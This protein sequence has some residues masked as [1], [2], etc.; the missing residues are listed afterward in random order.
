MG[1]D[2]YISCSL[3]ICKETGKLY[4]YGGARFE[5]I[6]NIPQL[7][8]P[9]EHREFVRM[10]GHLFGIYTRLVTDETSTSV[11]NFLD[12]Y[13][14]WS[15]ITESSDFEEYAEGWNE[16]MHERFYA[17]LIWFSLQDMNYMICWD[18]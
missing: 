12:K 8:V 9:E 2:I 1:F 6:Y 4:Y 15:D 5:K 18:Y 16:D 13:P 11:A 10:R 14:E 7:V 3:N 17:A